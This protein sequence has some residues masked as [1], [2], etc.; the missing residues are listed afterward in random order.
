MM[1][2]TRTTRK[3][4]LPRT[5]LRFAALGV[6]SALLL[7]SIA[8][9]QERTFVPPAPTKDANTVKPAVNTPPLPPVTTRVLKPEIPENPVS[10]P[11]QGTKP[12]SGG[13][14]KIQIT[15]RKKVDLSSYEKIFNAIPY[16]RSEYLANPSY[17]H[18]TTVEVMFGEMR[19]TV[20]HRQ[21][22]PQRVVNP[23]P[24]V[25][26][27]HIFREMEYWNWPGRF[28]QLLPGFGPVVA[29]VF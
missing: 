22:S 28:F 8:D 15:P 18:D 10:Q 7:S 9:A 27:P 24:R 20:V 6:L 17:R 13:E 12:L 26:D 4:Q 25:Y 16:R 5:V 21:D 11:S 14:W 3:K 2:A 23:R 19:S 1:D 29:P